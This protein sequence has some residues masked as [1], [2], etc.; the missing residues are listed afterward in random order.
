V[1]YSDIP[2]QGSARSLLACALDYLRY[3]LDRSAIAPTD[4]D[5]AWYKARVDEL[6]AQ[7]IPGTTNVASAKDTD[8]E[9]EENG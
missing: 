5:L 2:M 8:R 7:F 9:N 4:A 1:H 6:F 3:Y